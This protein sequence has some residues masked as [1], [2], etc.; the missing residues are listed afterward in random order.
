MPGERKQSTVVPLTG[1]GKCCLGYPRRR[2]VIGQYNPDEKASCADKD[3][4]YCRIASVACYCSLLP[5][6][7]ACYDVARNPQVVGQ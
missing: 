7:V 4:R 3:G 5:E 6:P 2:M 1:V